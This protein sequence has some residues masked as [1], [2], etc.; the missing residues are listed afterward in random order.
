VRRA[1][2]IAASCSR[3]AYRRKKAASD[4]NHGIG[5]ATGALRIKPNNII[6]NA[7]GFVEINASAES[8]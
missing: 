7:G 5:V 3:R 8:P 1:I 4:L 2:A 6:Q